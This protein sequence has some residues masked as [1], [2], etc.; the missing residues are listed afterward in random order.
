MV[1]LASYQ[2]G[3]IGAV[4][5]VLIFWLGTGVLILIESRCQQRRTE[6]R[7]QA[8]QEYARNLAEFSIRITKRRA[9]QEMLT[10]EREHRNLGGSGEV[11]EGTAVE[12]RR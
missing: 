2:A 8:S 10:A 12:V 11:I 4:V 7:R 9:I 6:W 3:L 5:S 1:A